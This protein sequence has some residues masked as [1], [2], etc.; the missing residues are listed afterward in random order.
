M[1]N[2]RYKRSTRFTRGCPAG[3][4]IVDDYVIEACRQAVTDY[5]AEHGVS[6]GDR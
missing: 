5:R 6:A 1:S 4:C 2:P 3:F